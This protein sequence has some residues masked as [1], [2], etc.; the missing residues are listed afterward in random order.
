MVDE[1]FSGAENKRQQSVRMTGMLL[2]KTPVLK[3]ANPVSSILV[4]SLLQY[5]RKMLVNCIP[6]KTCLG[7][8][9]KT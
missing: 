7:V 5:L 1:V 3:Q 4:H 8:G 9:S 6:L 2:K